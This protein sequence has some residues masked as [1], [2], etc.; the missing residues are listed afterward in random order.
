MSFEILGLDENPPRWN[1]QLMYSLVH[2]E[3]APTSENAAGILRYLINFP[4]N[5]TDGRNLEAA[6]IRVKAWWTYNSTP[7]TR[8]LI[9]NTIVNELEAVQKK[10]PV[11]ED[12]RYK[13][14]LA[15]TAFYINLADRVRDTVVNLAEG[16]SDH[17]TKAKLYAWSALMQPKDGSWIPRWLKLWHGSETFLW[18][19]SF[20]AIINSQ[21]YLAGVLMPGLFERKE[22]I[23]RKGGREVPLLLSRVFKKGLNWQQIA[24]EWAKTGRNVNHAE[25]VR[26]TRMLWE[27]AYGQETPKSSLQ[28][29]QEFGK[30]I[31]KQDE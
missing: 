23:N 21:P 14:I 30:L 7:A 13:M 31:Q 9:E 17:D 2:G 22:S 24:S 28:G 6:T 18:G 11:E 15:Q 19:V 29:L 27:N 5:L 20:S 16:E 8:V 10:K 3:Q 25:I 4:N 26:D 1:Y 12:K